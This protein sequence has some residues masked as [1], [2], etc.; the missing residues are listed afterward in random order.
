MEAYAGPH[1]RA[2]HARAGR[3]ARTD[4]MF[5]PPGHAYVYLVYGMHHCLNVVC[6]P[7]GE[8]GAVLIRAIEPIAGL[9]AMRS[10][11]ALSRRRASRSAPKDASDTGQTD[12]RGT[13]ARGSA[14][15]P[16]G[17]VG[18]DTVAA[19][20]ARGPGRL[21]A[22]FE[23][24]RSCNR[25]D[26]CA[27]DG[28]LRLVRDGQWNGPFTRSPRIGVGYAAEPWRSMPWRLVATD[29]LAVSQRRLTGPTRPLT[30]DPTVRPAP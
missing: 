23:I 11:T 9:E 25:L 29:D 5:G 28:T 21:C 2:S 19:V 20:I 16:G 3:T 12:R 22:A 6:G 14:A 13:R 18:Q 4:P 17:A 1:D 24:D 26:L 10:S 27:P 15:R 7:E 30:S 8:P